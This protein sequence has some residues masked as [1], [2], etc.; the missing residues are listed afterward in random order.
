MRRLLGLLA[1]VLFCA[2]L[3]ASQTAVVTR[4]VNLR[5]APST[6]G[7][8]WRSSHL[9]HN[10]RCLRPTRPMVSCMSKQAIRAVGVEQ[11]RAGSAIPADKWW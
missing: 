8:H 4:N 11:E 7:I 3:A 9:K 6:N 10:C 2:C 5:P 1:V